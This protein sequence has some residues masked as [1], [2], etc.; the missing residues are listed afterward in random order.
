MLS[1]F[2]KRFCTELYT[3]ENGQEGLELYKQHAPDIVVSDIKMPKMNGLEMIKEI[4]N[5]NKEQLILLL[6]AHSDSEYL[7]EAI[8]L[9]VDG[10]ILKPI[11]LDVVNDKVTQLTR[12]LENK[13]AMKALQESEEKFRTITQ[14]SLTGIFIYQETF[15]YVN[16]AF[17]EITGYSQEE[18]LTMAPWEILSAEYKDKGEELT[19][20]RVAGKLLEP[21][22]VQVDI[23]RKDGKI[24]TIKISTT[25]MPYKGRF[26]G[27]GNMMDITDIV[28]TKSRLK[29]LSQAVEQMDEMVRITDIDGNIIYV[30]PA[31]SKIT[32][33]D[34][35]EILGHNSKVFK[36]GKHSREFYKTLWDTI[37]SGK[38]YTNV[39]VNKKKDGT[40]YYD[41][42]V[43]SPMRN[44][45]GDIRYFVSTSR[46][47]SDRI[48]LENELKQLAT[49]DA[50]T[51]ILNRY[52][53][54]IK[55]EEE[56]KR[57]NRYEKPFGLLMFDIDYFKKVNDTY[58]HDV[59]D[60]VL[61]EI[62]HLVENT[63]RET[64]SFGRWGGEEFM[65]LMPYTSEET[66]VKI[67]E[68]IR[69]IIAKHTFK[70]VGH[71]TISI[72]VTFYKK[73]EEKEKLIKRVDTALY[74]AKA[75]GRNKVIS[76][77]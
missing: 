18:L 74:E 32:H 38:T 53:I 43:I 37:L 68:K 21:V 26:A 72:G 50:L 47:I 6:S 75:Q 29:L 4:K 11:D 41:E 57:V 40:L 52:K 35:D 22:Q 23:Q 31:T 27:T 70:D 1:R 39:L 66:L 64:D 46:D 15:T 65:I 19:K 13:K 44:E 58:G 77:F 8:N 36:S 71:V 54:N 12:I 69:Q 48:T 5:L 20:Q 30:N 56:I 76:L 9:N 59:G 10:Y 34:E 67:A 2:L 7:F 61:Q 42:K 16:H 60:Y 28:Q 45:L 3:A 55:I 24:C 14:V 51:G 33:Y 49:K 63:I 73:H 62:S 17:C 25:T